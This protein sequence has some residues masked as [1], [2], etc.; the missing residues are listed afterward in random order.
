[1]CVYMCIHHVQQLTKKIR[2]HTHDDSE[3]HSQSYT[4]PNDDVLPPPLPKLQLRKPQGIRHKR[5]HRR[6][7]TARTLPA[8]PAE[9]QSIENVA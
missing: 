5:A 3:H 9:L 8:A 2:L 6:H 4:R 7:R 1:M